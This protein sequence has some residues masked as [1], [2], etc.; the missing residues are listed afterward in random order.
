MRAVLGV[1]LLFAGCGFGTVDPGERATFATW[2][3]LDQQCYKEGFYT[4]NP[5]STDMHRIDTKVQAYKVAKLAAVTQDLQAINADVVVNFSIDGDKC[6]ELVQTV[7]F[8]FK[9]RVIIPS[10]AEV[11]KASTAHFPIDRIIRERARLRDEIIAGLKARLAPYRIDVRDVAL[12]NFDFDPAFVKA[13]EQKQIEEQ[14]VQRFEY[15]R[16]QAEKQAQTDVARAEGNAKANKLLAESLR[17]SPETLRFKELDVLEKKWDGRFPQF[18]GGGVPLIQ[19][20]G[21]S[22]GS[23]GGM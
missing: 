16:Q 22:R 12:V 18:M 2:G 17:Q 6:H 13:V 3:K 11:L 23:G 15:L 19:V 21:I 9:E 8:D 10:T 4:Y 7:G 5:L 1:A 14:N 20:P